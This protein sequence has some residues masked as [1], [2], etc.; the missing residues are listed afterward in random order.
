MFLSEA[1]SG[2]HV[3][4]AYMAYRNPSA[5]R[6]PGQTRVWEDLRKEAR[7]LEGELDVK[8]AAFTKLCSSFEA[9]YKLNS[10][11]NAALG[12]DQL[13]QTKAAEV[14]D[15]LQ[16]LSDVNDEMAATVGGSTDSRSHTLA[17]H[18]DILQEFTQEFRKVNATL[19]AALDRV[20]LLAGS[21]ETPL[22]SVQVQSS[23]GALLRERGTIQNSTNMVDDLLSQAS[24][25]SG[26]LM[27]QR[28]MFEGIADKLV[29][30]GSRFPVVNGLLNAIRRKKSKD[31]LVLSGV[32]AA[33]VI[34]TVIYVLAK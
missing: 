23:S 15:L 27:Q 14:E 19:G 20:K 31:T 4:T 3:A 24:N 11:D 25:V 21:T 17:R 5:P 30:V 29:T 6:A 10:T 16:R 26:N 1:P 2:R 34:F 33:C 22:L 7:R 8:L 32:V 18:R 12:A 28:R 13:A 9:S